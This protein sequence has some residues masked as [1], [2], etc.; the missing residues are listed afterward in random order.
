MEN[1]IKAQQEI[2]RVASQ[3]KPG[4]VHI[5]CKQRHFVSASGNRLVDCLFDFDIHIEPIYDI[6]TNPILWGRV[7]GRLENEIDNDS[8]DVFTVVVGSLRE[9]NEF[10][11]IFSK[12][13]L[14][15]RQNFA[16]GDTR[17]IWIPNKQEDTTNLPIIGSCQDAD[18]PEQCPNLTQAGDSMGMLMA[19]IKKVDDL[20]AE[21]RKVTS[22][23]MYAN[24][25][26]KYNIDA[27]GI[28]QEISTAPLDDYEIEIRYSGR[29]ISVNK[30]VGAE[31]KSNPKLK[32]SNLE[33]YLSSAQEAEPLDL[34]PIEKAIYL[35]MLLYS[36]KGVYIEKLDTYNKKL[37]KDY[38]AFFDILIEIYENLPNSRRYDNSDNSD[39]SVIIHIRQLKCIQRSTF[40]GYKKNIKD[41]IAAQIKNTRL[42]QQFS[43]EGPRNG[44]NRIE[45]STPELREEIRKIFSLS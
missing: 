11:L 2:L 29:T 19:P 18:K 14:A 24:H 25:F 5:F 12:S 23:V 17:T 22:D 9:Y 10:A 13:M 42:A 43:I 33:I 31:I 45:K 6:T 28:Y 21:F 4:E 37:D 36:E 27:D 40:L 1:Y 39:N 35:T 30:V 44:L 3:L 41:K 34:Q 15:D 8:A 16:L 7:I 32:L 26:E 38:K 20:S